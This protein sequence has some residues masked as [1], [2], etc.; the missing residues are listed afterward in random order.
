MTKTF[1][2]SRASSYGYHDV[3][4]S[5]IEGAYPVQDFDGSIHWMIEVHDLS[6]LMKLVEKVYNGLIIYPD[7]ITI[8]DS[9]IE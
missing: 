9:Y 7:S 5:P 8:Y 1:K 4:E 6:H 3:D 2:I